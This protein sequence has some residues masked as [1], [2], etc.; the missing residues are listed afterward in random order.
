MGDI[1]RWCVYVCMCVYVYVFVIVCVT[2]GVGVGVGVCVCVGV[3][4]C[5]CVRAWR[6]QSSLTRS[7][8]N[9]QLSLD[10]YSRYGNYLSDL[11]PE[12]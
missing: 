5:A 10:L 4:R 2:V 6:V 8:H 12:F 11:L 1:A 3:Y 7:G 9:S